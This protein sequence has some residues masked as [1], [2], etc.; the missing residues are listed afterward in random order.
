LHYASFSSA[1]FEVGLPGGGNNPP[2]VKEC[3]V[4]KK[5]PLKNETKNADYAGL[6]VISRR[7]ISVNS[8]DGL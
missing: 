8:K 3:L 1:R 6:A 5:R 7:V 4:M 2:S